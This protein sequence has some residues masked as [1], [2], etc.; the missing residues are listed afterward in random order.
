MKKLFALLLPLLLLTG[1]SGIAS[2]NNILN[3]LS[4][5]K[6]SER[7]SRIIA[8]L[9]EYAGQEVRLKYPKKGD[10]LS[11]VQIVDLDGDGR[12]EAVV[13]YS[14]P[15]S[16]TVARIALMKNTED[17]WTLLQD[18]EGYGSEIY[19]VSFEH[20]GKGPEKQILVGYTF[21]DDSEILLSVYFLSEEN[22]TEL[23]TNPCQEYVVHDVTGD[24]ISDIVLAG[25]NAGNQ[26]T[27]L[28]LFS[29]HYNDYLT[30]LV[31]RTIDV[32]NIDVTNIAFSSCDRA[33]R[34]VILVDYKDRYH[35]VYTEA[36]HYDD[37]EMSTVLPADVVQK[38]WYFN[39]ELNSRDVDGDGYLET[40]TIIDDGT[41]YSHN[42]KQMEWTCFLKEA[43]Q[44]VYYGVCE[45]ESG[46]F[47]PLPDEWL[48]HITLANGDREGVWQVLQTSDGQVLV[49]FELIS[50]AGENDGENTVT[51]SK[52]TVQVKITFHEDV[53]SLQREY[54]S[55]GLMYLK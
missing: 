53:S 1:C 6:L 18:M 49:Q 17:G 16:G 3:L 52:G 21:S 30:N 25:I 44:R 46:T 48:N 47:F 22:E 42:L 28:K 37:F 14:L 50:V 27:Q 23:H 32:R 35:R 36:I 7:E 31:S 13:M 20:L 15:S 43:P 55:T 26:R 8:S 24:G 45:A 10:N 39:Y 2:R 29:T 11:P 19:R 33:E 41:S 40:P 34:E 54:I 9:N 4:A 5:P 38:I 51:V 12:D